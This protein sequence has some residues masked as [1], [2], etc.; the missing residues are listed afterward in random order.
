MF[1]TD[2]NWITF[3]SLSAHELRKSPTEVRTF[4]WIKTHAGGTCFVDAA[5][6]KQPIKC[7]VKSGLYH[8]YRRVAAA[9]RLIGRSSIIGSS[10]DLHVALHCLSIHLK[11]SE[12]VR[13][14]NDKTLFRSYLSHFWDTLHKSFSSLEKFSFKSPFC[15][16][17]QT[18]L[19][20]LCISLL[21]IVFG[22][23]I[24]HSWGRILAR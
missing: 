14:T 6:R 15:N 22:N 18:Q 21:I 23:S 2:T 3:Q 5:R 7:R 1:L 10:S 8:D 16:N 17:L 12:R 9:Q 11:L 4:A 20:I 13:W 24:I 19:G